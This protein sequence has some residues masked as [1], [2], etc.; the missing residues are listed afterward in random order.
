MRK[1][2]KDV[3]GWQIGVQA[4]QITVDTTA[5]DEGCESSKQQKPGL[6]LKCEQSALT[7][8]HPL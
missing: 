6:N 4:F 8:K 3:T 1:H 7:N 2:K 5:F